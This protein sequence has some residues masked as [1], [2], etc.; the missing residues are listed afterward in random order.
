MRDAERGSPVSLVWA[1]EAFYFHKV[2]LWDYHYDSL[3]FVI[4]INS[5]QDSHQQ[6]PSSKWLVCYEELPEEGQDRSDLLPWNPV[7]WLKNCK[8]FFLI[9]Q[10]WWWWWW[11]WWWSGYHSDKK[12]VSHAHTML[13]PMISY[14]WFPGF[15]GFFFIF[16]WEVIF[17]GLVFLI[18]FNVHWPSHEKFS[19][20][21]FQGLFFNVHWPSLSVASRGSGFLFSCS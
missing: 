10:W 15:R 19:S 2:Y 6:A 3:F 16:P 9:H 12:M 17:P 21:G 11:W 1:W 4:G 7:N 8:F 20:P 14:M 18:C 5:D 13:Q